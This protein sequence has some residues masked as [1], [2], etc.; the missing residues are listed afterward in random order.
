MRHTGTYRWRWGRRRL[1]TAD[2]A[3]CQVDTCTIPSPCDERRRCSDYH[4]GRL[5][6]DLRDSCRHHH[7]HLHHHLFL[8]LF[9]VIFLFLFIFFSR[10]FSLFLLSPVFYLSSCGCFPDTALACLKTPCPHHHHHHITITF[11]FFWFFLSFFVFWGSS[12]SSSSCSPAVACLCSSC[13]LCWFPCLSSSLVAF[14]S[15][16]CCFTTS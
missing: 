14:R 13:L 3:Q 6:D 2:R 9:L 10:H 7:H 12:F 1:Q 15:Y 4:Q 11:V 16:T 5:T 8:L